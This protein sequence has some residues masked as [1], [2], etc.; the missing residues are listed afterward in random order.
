MNVPQLAGLLR[1]YR[2]W[3]TVRRFIRASS[4]RTA[5]LIN[6]AVIR[7]GPGFV[8]S[9]VWLKH[10]YDYAVVYIDPRLI[11]R[12]VQMDGWRRESESTSLSGRLRAWYLY[13][14][15]L[16][17]V[18][19]HVTRNLHGKFVAGGDWDIHAKPFE[20][21]PVIGQ[22]FGEGRPPQ[23]TDEY[24][25]Y[26]ERIEEGRLAWTRGCRSQ[27]EL[28]EYYARLIRAYEDIRDNGYR[29]QTELGESGGDEIRVCIDRA[30]EV[31]V[32]GGGTHRLSIARF[33]ELDVVPVSLK[34]IHSSW[35]A[36]IDSSD[37]ALDS[38]NIRRELERIGFQ[39]RDVPNQ[40]NVK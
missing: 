3:P 8:G 36:P 35:L 40:T 30:G 38:T 17:S 18:R 1:R 21:L 20:I 16:K 28:D 12:H 26:L 10:S 7:A 9:N 32:Y 23:E 4:S 5:G 13:G 37:T 22:L 25:S 6:S 24:Q 2:F 11:S 39:A 14:D 27:A 31:C 29:L 19:T 33:L 15:G 34:R